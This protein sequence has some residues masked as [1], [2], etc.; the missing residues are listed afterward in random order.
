[1]DHITKLDTRKTAR[2]CFEGDMGIDYQDS[3]IWRSYYLHFYGKDL[4]EVLESAMISEVDQDGGEIN[5]YGIEDATN[6]V[7]I[8]AYEIIESAIKEKK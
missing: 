7:Q 5:S 4:K 6:N 3:G 2:Y 8:I 1:M